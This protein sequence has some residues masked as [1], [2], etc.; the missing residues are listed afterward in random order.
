MNLDHKAIGQKL[1]LFHFSAAASG[2]AFWH[3][4]GQMV[5]RALEEHVRRI[6][7]ADGFEEVKG[8]QVL[9]ADVWKKSGHWDKFGDAMLRLDSRH[10]AGGGALKPVSCPGTSKS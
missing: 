1:D 6:V 8:P 4:R 10:G 7:A 9:S 3:P 5:L 2:A